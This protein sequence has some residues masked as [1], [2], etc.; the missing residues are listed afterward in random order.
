MLT[1]E[2]A[3]RLESDVDFKAFKA[4]CELALE[5]LDSLDGIDFSDKEKAAIQGEGR[6]EA[7]KILETIL[8]P[9]VQGSESTGDKKKE[10]A[11]KYGVDV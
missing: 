5:A 7:R 9:F 10:A 11:Q 1:N 2:L 3:K 8:E 4:H 6:R